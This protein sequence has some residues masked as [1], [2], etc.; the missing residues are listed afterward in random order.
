METQK[1]DLTQFT[2][3]NVKIVPAVIEAVLVDIQELTAEEI[4]GGKAYEPLKKYLR[5]SF[6]CAKHDIKTHEDYAF[7][8][9]EELNNKSK[10]GKYVTKYGDLSIGTTVMMLQNDAGFFEVL[11]E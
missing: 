8:P 11:L 2:K 4:F 6:E 9:I 5:M 7:Y 3:A 10:L 1:T